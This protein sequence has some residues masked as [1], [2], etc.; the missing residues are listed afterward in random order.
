M[1][2]VS[3]ASLMSFQL[4]LRR[5]HGEGAYETVL[6]KMPAA[7][8]EPLR[9][10][11]LPVNWYPTVSFVRAIE[12]AHAQLGSD[13]LY[14]RYGTFAA[15]FQINTFQKLLL[16]FTSPAYM[17]NRAGRVWHRFHETGEWNVSSGT[18]KTMRG[19]LRNFSVVSSGY[20]RVVRAW[21][22]RAGQMTGTDGGVDHPE[23]RAKGA[24][25]CV[26]TGWWK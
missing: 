1:S 22:L 7:Q 8:A 24:A 20:C 11:I 19:E 17:L 2:R 14:E 18:G 21:I 12:T 16:R 5:E 25:V 26:F 6:A 13:D 3:G 4:F 10:I 9:G 15:E 23:C